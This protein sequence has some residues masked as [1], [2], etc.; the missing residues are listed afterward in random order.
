MIS[1]DGKDTKLLVEG[2]GLREVMNIDG[3][4][5]LFFFLPVRITNYSQFDLIYLGV[6]G[7]KTKSN[8]TLEMHKTL[9][10][11]AA[12]NNIIDEIIYTMVSHGMTID[13]RHVMLMADLMTFKVGY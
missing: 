10:I 6:E 4:E 13:R 12:R 2:L 1:G 3:N 5:E 7:T 9:G 11:E 8:H